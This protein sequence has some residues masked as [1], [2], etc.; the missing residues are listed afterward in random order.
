MIW[1][2]LIGA[3]ILA[4]VFKKLPEK[5]NV[6]TSIHYK[7][8]TFLLTP[9]ELDFFHALKL[10]VSKNETI[11]AK[12][13]QAD[14][15]ETNYQKSHPAFWSKFNKISQR[16]FD[17][18]L[19]DA[20]TSKPLCV[21]E[22]NDKSHRR[23]DRIRRD[24]EVREALKHTSIQLIE[25]PASSSYN[26]DE[27][28]KL[29]YERVTYYDDPAAKTNGQKGIRDEHPSQFSPPQSDG[30]YTRDDKDINE[31]QMQLKQKVPSIQKKPSPTHPV[32]QHPDS[33]YMPKG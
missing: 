18:V 20:Q 33:R 22:I 19:C 26:P 13:R 32:L 24:Q 9:T 30:K 3:I 7:E 21:I 11:F 6:S 2:I 1:F 31:Q 28:R 27:V 5:T 16:H 12:V 14:V 4:I 17:F 23:G 15:L 10:A 25:I 29:I 8:R